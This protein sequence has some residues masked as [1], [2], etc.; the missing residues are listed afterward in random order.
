MSKKVQIIYPLEYDGKGFKLNDEY[1]ETK[2]FKDLLKR[3]HKEVIDDIN[4][5]VD[6][7][8]RR[9]ELECTICPPN[10]GENKTRYKRTKTKPKYKDKRK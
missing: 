3:K 7:K 6:K 1:K 4:S 5:S 10:K 9:K 2:E 8:E